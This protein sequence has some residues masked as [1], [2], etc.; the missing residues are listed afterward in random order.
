MRPTAIG[1]AA[2]WGLAA[3]SGCHSAATPPAFRHVLLV[4]IDTLRADHLGCYGS[5]FVRSPHID[6]VAS[7]GLL[8]EQHISVAPST[9]AS[10]TSLMTGTYPRTHGA[11][12]NRVRVG[13]G[14]RML[15]ELLSEAGFETAA[16]IGGL[17][18]A[19]AV[20][21]QQG[22]GHYREP[23]P[24]QHRVPG[25]E[26]TDAA[27][28]WI[29]AA[30][31]E[32]SFAFVHYFDVHQPYVHGEPWDSMYRRDDLGELPG[33][34][35]LRRALARGEPGA[36]ELSRATRAAYAGGVTYVDDQIGRL[37]EGL[38]RSGWLDEALV[39]VTSDHGEAMDEHADELWNHGHTLYD[40]TVR[41]PLVMR[42]PGAWRAGTRIPQ[43]VANIDL[44]PTL[45]ELLGLPLPDGIEGRSLVPLLL[46]GAGPVRDLVFV[47]ATR[48]HDEAHEAGTRWPNERKLRGVR[49]QRWKLVHAPLPDRIQA[50]DLDSD[51]GEQTDLSAAAR[52]GAPWDALR[53]SLDAWAAGEAAPATRA[54]LDAW[55][56]EQL[57][58]L[59]YAE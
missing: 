7:E 34:G 55:T 33:P 18:L 2:A 25:A 59:G 22:F 10:H 24:P 37:L 54:E 44:V 1:A 23:R 58:A 12:H 28:A 29:G 47:E 31:R 20:H 50:F 3:L 45:L 46:G 41:T 21:F 8:F 32:R 49:T 35:P 6:R 30:A 51:P 19:S 5:P 4:S 36:R 42:F 11:A 43:L 17:P 53:S 56:E 14:N 15:A 52:T 48:P 26:V 27:L 16:F 39:V 9:L 40:E 57:G 13:D 38:S